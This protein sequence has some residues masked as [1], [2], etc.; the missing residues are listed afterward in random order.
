MSALSLLT[1]SIPNWAK[2]KNKIHHNKVLLN[3]FPMNGL[4]FCHPRF[5]SGSQR[6]NKQH[7][8]KVLLNSFPMVTPLG[9]VH[10]IKSWKTVYHP[11]F[12]IITLEVKGLMLHLAGLDATILSYR[13]LIHLVLLC[14][15]FTVFQALGG[16]LSEPDS[17]LIRQLE[18]LL[19]IFTFYHGSVDR[20]RMV[21][22][23]N[24]LT[25]ARLVSSETL[26]LIIQCF[27]TFSLTCKLVFIIIIIIIIILMMIMIMIM[28]MIM[29]IMIMI[30]IMII[31]NDNDNDNK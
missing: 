7:H 16:D 2:L 20:M 29:M 12:I 27:T 8:S 18:T 19:S 28:I 11:R 26:S 30:M 13:L 31:N 9:F 22:K 15:L 14:T 23:S 21:S 17:L 5:H 6:V 25:S 24:A 1:F 4:W 10:R 3:S